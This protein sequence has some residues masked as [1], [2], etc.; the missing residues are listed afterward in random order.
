M[1]IQKKD[2]RL[3]G[4][5]KKVNSG[6]HLPSEPPYESVW[7]YLRTTSPLLSVT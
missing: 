7:K 2:L 3:S 1:K 5:I 4:D 6:H